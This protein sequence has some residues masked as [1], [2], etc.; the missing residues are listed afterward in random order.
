[1]E[2]AIIPP[3]FHRAS[4]P[5]R[6][7]NDGAISGSSPVTAATGA[8]LY[9]LAIGFFVHK[10]L[11][12]EHLKHSLETMTWLNGPALLTLFTATVF[13]RLPVEA[14]IWL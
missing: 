2:A 5:W 4:R 3:H 7:P 8:I 10:E 14:V 13:G 1:M 11:K 12:F 6:P 9:T